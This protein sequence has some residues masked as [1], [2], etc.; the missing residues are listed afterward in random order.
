MPGGCAKGIVD[1]N[2]ESGWRYGCTIPRNSG[3]VAD[4]PSFARRCP[5][6]SEMKRLAHV[7]PEIATLLERERARQNTTI[8]LIASQSSVD[9]AILAAQGS[10]LTNL[11]IEGYP[12][13]RYFPGC[14]YADEVERLAIDRAKALFGAEHANVQ[15]H[16]GVNA[17]S[18]VYL[19]ALQPGATVLGLSLRHGGHLSHGY[20]LSLSGQFYRFRHYAVDRETEQ[21]DYES[22]RELARRE[23]P[24]MIVAGGS[25]YPR[26][27]DFAPLREIC[28]EV[29]AVLLV[30]QAHFG[31]LVA[32]G[33]HPD[34]VPL[35]EFVTGTTYKT[36]GGAKGGYI[37]CRSAYAREV[38]RAVFPGVQGSF[39]PH[40]I[41]AKA[42]SFNMAMT[43]GFRET[44]RQVVAHARLLAR[45]LQEAGWR[46]VTGGTDTHL[47]LVDV[48]SRGLTGQQA[49]AALERA[50][51]C[52]NRNLI[53]YDVRP[54]LVASGIRIGT[55]AVTFRGFGRAE[56]EQV[57]DV[58]VAVLERPED[59]STQQKARARVGEL[60]RRFPLYEGR[61]GR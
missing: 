9:E 11:T 44:Q 47:V 27:I 60:C 24:R 4:A 17:N 53:P 46:V 26:A 48:G 1:Y 49:E 39:G 31:G 50:G 51:I 42:V 59:E 32:A 58:M 61:E 19:A 5:K 57:A 56:M 54:P 41:A 33:L 12:G 20:E 28:D 34:P 13:R 22:V 36:L 35:A 6:G 37:L 18:A 8:Q 21:I 40:T 7:D 29:G 43:E 25:A 30:D 10:I 2:R 23:R 38:D 52:V 16:S 3:K 45:R 15:P 55:A 14:E